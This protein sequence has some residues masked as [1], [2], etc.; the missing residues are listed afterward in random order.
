YPGQ[1]VRW[2]AGDEP[3]DVVDL[4]AGTGKLTRVLVALGY[5]VTAI[6]PL[7]EMR[8]QL[9][10][11]VPGVRA[12]EGRA[13]AMPLADASADVVTSA[14]AFHWFD[15]DDAL[16][17]IARVLRAAGRIA[18][19]WNS[20]DDRDPWMARLSAIIGNESVVESDVVPILDASGLFGSV[21]KATFSFEQVLDRD[22]LLD[23]VLSRSY[24][25]KLPAAERQ[26]VLD[27]VGALFDETAT[28]GGVRL[29]Y[30]TDCYRARKGAA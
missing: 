1:A 23:L 24:L 28:D 30:V 18:L 27:E 9:A 19:V 21:E 20:R 16:P 17:E 14:Q 22:G 13:E 25:A 7:A 2:L 12:L 8:A 5:R 15:H 4:G 10:L 11:V 29:A 6:E 26:P 3:A